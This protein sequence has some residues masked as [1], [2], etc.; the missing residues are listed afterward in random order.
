[1]GRL[2]WLYAAAR[3]LSA[4][5]FL[6]ARSRA[7]RGTRAASRAEQ[8]QEPAGPEPQLGGC[9]GSAA[10]TLTGRSGERCSHVSQGNW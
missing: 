1:M 9:N 2:M 8:E 3:R 7:A 6:T 4:P 5:G 10:V